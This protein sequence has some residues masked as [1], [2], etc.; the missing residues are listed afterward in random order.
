MVG[1]PDTAVK[2]SIERVR[3]AVGNSGYRF[4]RYKVVVN[5]APADLRKV[6][7]NTPHDSQKTR[8]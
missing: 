4:P 5:L 6:G 8:F 2:E 3:S 7:P 1:L